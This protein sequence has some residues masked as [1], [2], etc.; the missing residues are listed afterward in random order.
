VISDAFLLRLQREIDIKV[1]HLEARVIQI[2]DS[3]EFRHHF[4]GINLSDRFVYRS[5]TAH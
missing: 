5:L 3:R 4:P 1:M 2:G